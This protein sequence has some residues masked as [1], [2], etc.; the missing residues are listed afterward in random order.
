MVKHYKPLK[1]LCCIT[2]ISSW[3]KIATLFYCRSVNLYCTPKVAKTDLCFP[4]NII[5]Y[6]EERLKENRETGN[7]ILQKWLL[8]RSIWYYWGI[9]V[10]CN[11]LL[12]IHAST[13]AEVCDQ[14]TTLNIEEAWQIKRPRHLTNLKFEHT[15]F[16]TP[17]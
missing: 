8:T 17:I 10:C 12:S 5:H 3:C 11:G 4:C 15:H 13:C 2:K 1:L 7:T 6:W 14:A 16:L 9:L